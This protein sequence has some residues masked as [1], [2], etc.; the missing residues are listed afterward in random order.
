VI[1]L[2]LNTK[3]FERWTKLIDGEITQL[4]FALASAMNTAAF[5]AR[6]KLIEETW[7][8][9]VKVRDRNF[10]KFALRVDQ[11]ATKRSL[12]VAITDRN[13]NGRGNLILHAKGGTKPARRLLAIPDRKVRRGAKGVS[14]NQR[15]AALP[16]SFRKGDIIYQRYGAKGRKLRLMYTLKPSARIKADVPFHADFKRYMLAGVRKSFPEAMARAMRPRGRK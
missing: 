2:L 6:T 12:T 13:S 8:A 10:L 7:P 11:K 9:H 14:A 16:N 3:A 1:D 15:P 5:E 4:P